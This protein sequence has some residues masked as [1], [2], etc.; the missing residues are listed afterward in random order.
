M[1]VGKIPNDVLKSLVINRIKD[2]REEIIVRPGIGEDCGIAD[3][4]GNLIAMSSDPITGTPE[5]IGHL[6]VHVSCNDIASCGAEPVGILVTLLLPVG[7]TKEDLDFIMAQICKEADSINVDIMGGHT[8]I[9]TAVNR[10]VAI[11]TSIGKV[12][13]G[14]IV[15]TSG[16]KPGDYVVIT[17]S[18]GLEGTAIIAKL[19]ESELAAAL[20]QKTVENA[21]SFINSISVVK[22]GMIA[23]RFGVNAMHDVTEGGVLG[24]V[25]EIAEASAT[26]VIVQRNDVPVAPETK[27][28][29]DYFGIDPLK[30]ISSGSMA[31]SCADGPGLVETLERNGIKAAVIGRIT[32]EVERK[33]IYEGQEY[34][35]NQPDT[36]ELY[37]VVE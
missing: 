5:D 11:C 1:K 25:W 30:L 18:A 36:D 12:Q 34:E 7:T 20:G 33:V 26:G 22:E 14:S 23:A 31:I 17:K 10:T 16:A 3:F 21:K 13:K 8:E 28:I 15:K 32:A 9:T 6:A 37:K 24:A 4:G 29:C 27:A 19:K 2:K 35:L